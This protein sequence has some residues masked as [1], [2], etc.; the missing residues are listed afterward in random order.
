MLKSSLFSALFA[1]VLLQTAEFTIPSRDAQLGATFKFPDVGKPPFPAVVLV[2]GSGRVTANDMLDGSGRR[3]AA[4]G[5]AVLA[6]DK[7]G[8]GRSTGVYT[9]VGTSNSVEMFDLLAG[10]AIAAVGLLKK[11][12]DVDPARIGLVGI[13]QG[14]WI[15]PLAATRSRDISFVV[16]ISG[17]A[18]SVG[19]EIAYSRLAGE[20][21]GSEQGVSDEEIARRMKSFRGPAGY[22]PAETLKLLAT[23]SL[24]IL[25]QKDRSIPL[26]HTV[27]VLT[28]LK[29]DAQKPITIHVIPGVNH[30]LM[31]PD[32]GR[33]PDFWQVIRT[34]LADQKV[35]R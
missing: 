31:S 34:W 6:Y 15:A 26:Q 9:N 8:V 25:G 24:W 16:T 7:R 10:D 20:D 28:G 12:T 19:E 1:L 13:S 22:D 33:S 18:V 21:P 2:H 23:P 27:D 3:L 11:R 17:P 32:G 14:G 4:L 35:L 29:R 5:L 30:R